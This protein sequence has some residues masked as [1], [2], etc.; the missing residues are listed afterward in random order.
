MIYDV[1]FIPRREVPLVLA[2]LFASQLSMVAEA[3]NQ[4]DFLS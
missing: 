3:P 4:L 2:G 1:V